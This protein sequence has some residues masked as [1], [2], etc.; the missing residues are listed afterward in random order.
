MSTSVAPLASVPTMSIVAVPVTASTP[1]SGVCRS[2]GGMFFAAK[3]TSVARRINRRLVV[4]NRWFKG[5]SWMWTTRNSLTTPK[6]GLSACALSIKW[7][8]TSSTGSCMASA[9]AA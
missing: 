5:T 1:G 7:V 4:W 3:R 2:V 8:R 6:A 9:R